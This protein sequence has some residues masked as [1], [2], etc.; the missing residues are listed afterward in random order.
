MS[1]APSLRNPAL[2]SPHELI[3]AFYCLIS[4]SVCVC[5]CA[6]A[7]VCAFVHARLLSQFLRY[8]KLIPISEPLDML[9]LWLATYFSQIFAFLQLRYSG[10]NSNPASS[11]R[12]CPSEA[13]HSIL[14]PGALLRQP[15]FIF[16]IALLANLYFMSLLFTSSLKNCKLLQ[17][18]SCLLLSACIQSSTWHRVSA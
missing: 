16:Y 6:R 3:P 13:A 10:M 2:Q 4:F 5:V 18:L 8:A 15:A 1:I 17:D 11:E 12:H 7:R 14:T 9:C